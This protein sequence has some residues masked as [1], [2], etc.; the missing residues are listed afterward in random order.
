LTI[1]ADDDDDDDDE[2]YRFLDDFSGHGDTSSAH[3]DVTLMT[4]QH[5]HLAA[6]HV[7]SSCDTLL[8]IILVTLK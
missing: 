3:S 2:N 7:P 5:G 1:A 8:F 6:G 4:S